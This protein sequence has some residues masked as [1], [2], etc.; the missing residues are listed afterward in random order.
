MFL[1]ALVQDSFNGVQK[2]RD[3]E[4]SKEKVDEKLNSKSGPTLLD[5]NKT[6][7]AS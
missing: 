6:T 1:E 3:N 2:E 4:R 5:N 7:A